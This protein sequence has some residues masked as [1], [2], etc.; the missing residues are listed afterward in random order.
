M[1]TT[2]ARAMTVTSADG[3][4]SMPASTA[5]VR[6]NLVVAL[7][8]KLAERAGLPRAIFRRATV[9]GRAPLFDWFISTGWTPRE[10]RSSTDF[11]AVTLNLGFQ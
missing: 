4:I 3:D 10:R 2:G 11:G 6:A 9:T 1:R 5:L 8:G 7:R